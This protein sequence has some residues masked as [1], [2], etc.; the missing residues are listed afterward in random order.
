MRIFIS[1]IV[2]YLILIAFTL[3]SNMA[4]FF[5]FCMETLGLDSTFLL[6]YI[7]TKIY[8]NYRLKIPNSKIAILA[9]L[10]LKKTIDNESRFCPTNEGA[11]HPVL[12]VLI[13]KT[14]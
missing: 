3:I 4:V 7:F 11:C 12:F 6:L 1:L 2:L 5:L 8:A 14:R 10:S 9:F 13:A